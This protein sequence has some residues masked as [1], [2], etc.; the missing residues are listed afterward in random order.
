MTVG[1]MVAATMVGLA[2][3]AMAMEGMK[4]AI[5]KDTTAKEDSVMVAAG[6]EPMLQYSDSSGVAL[7]SF[8]VHKNGSCF[9]Q[10]K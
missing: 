5:V 9:H 3:V 10:Q 6:S 2:V 7:R 8:A 4:V 1:V